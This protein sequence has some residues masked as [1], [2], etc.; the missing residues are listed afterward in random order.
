MKSKNQKS[1]LKSAKSQSRKSA[2]GKTAWRC[3][4]CG[5][6]EY[7]DKPPQECPYCLY[8]NQPFKEVEEEES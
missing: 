1:G 2:S 3:E 4:H 5:E 8:P 7:A 6:I